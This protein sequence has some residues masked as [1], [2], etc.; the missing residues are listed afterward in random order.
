[1]IKMRLRNKTKPVPVIGLS[2]RSRT[3]LT[4]VRTGPSDRT[5]L[6]PVMKMSKKVNLTIS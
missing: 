2:P 4:L 1:M 6:V 5:K 3:K